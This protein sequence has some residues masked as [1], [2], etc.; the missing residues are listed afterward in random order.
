[1]LGLVIGIILIPT[2]M[3]IFLRAGRAI[4]DIPVYGTGRLIESTVT[5]SISIFITDLG[6]AGLQFHDAVPATEG[7]V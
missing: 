7:I 6:N 1:M 5:P 3:I 2:A 4:R